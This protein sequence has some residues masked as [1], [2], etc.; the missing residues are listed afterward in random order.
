MKVGLLRLPAPQ[1]FTALVL[2]IFSI[3][4]ALRSGPNGESRSVAGAAA[5]VNM[6][7]LVDAD[8]GSARLQSAGIA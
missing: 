4:I 6:P 1:N 8:Q 2:G 7:E 3:W 5:R